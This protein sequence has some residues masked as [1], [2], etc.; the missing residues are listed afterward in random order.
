MGST[1]EQLEAR[2]SKLETMSS[3]T[4]IVYVWVHAG[5]RAVEDLRYSL[6]S[7]EE[8]WMR[9][10]YRVFIVGDRPPHWGDFM[11][12]PHAHESSKERG[13]K[14]PK[15]VDA[16]R[17]MKAI[18]DCPQ[19]GEQFVYMSDDVALLRPLD[20]EYLAVRRAAL[21]LD[22][23]QK[24]GGTKW[25]TWIWNT[26]EALKQAGC[27]RVWNYETHL[28]RVFE[29]RRMREVIARFDP[30]KNHLLLPTL[31]FNYFHKD[32]PPEL[33]HKLDNVRVVFFDTEDGLSHGRSREREPERACAYH[34][35]RM[36]GK[37]LLC[38]N[39][40]GMK[41]PGLF[42]AIHALFPRKSAFEQLRVAPPPL[43][44]ER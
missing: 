32:Q 25:R 5:D 28:P 9:G 18:L 36:R 33:L 38:W 37:H 31:Y 22:P 15:A 11:H 23:A 20:A 44:I 1:T 6:R 10:S 7:V 29:K 24:V 42:Y 8:N 35:D 14:Y 2:G 17:K 27:T 30:E 3:H 16:V 34:L 26:Y 39:N 12:L 43:T 13:L 41:D 19:I 4:D 40:N 21:E